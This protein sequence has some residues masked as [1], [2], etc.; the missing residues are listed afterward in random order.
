VAA[1]PQAER[2]GS[3][4]YRQIATTLI[5]EIRDGRWQVGEPMPT[6]MDLVERFG[7]GR[8]T[9]R[10]ALRELEGLGYI[11]R[12]RGARSTLRST[13]P[14]GAFVNSVR[15]VEELVEYATST[16]ATL[17][18]SEIVRIDR[19]LAERLDLVPDTELLRVGILRS[20]DAGDDPFCY[21]EVYLDPKYRDVAAMIGT[22][23][24]LFPLIEKHHNVVLRR[25]VQETEAA[26]ADAN[27]ASRLNIAVGSPI[28]LVRTKFFSTD[29]K[30]VETGLSHFPCG[31]YR[32][33]IALDRRSVDMP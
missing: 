4:G 24:Q 13:S 6:E 23:T 33:R 18:A 8:N 15:S 19:A 12:R 21:S 27:I 28:L 17:L 11:E 3:V 16:R 2:R 20:R 9:V 7:V 1:A 14:E 29:G 26:A 30:M 22:E 31:R 10:E 25:V 32:V 5:R